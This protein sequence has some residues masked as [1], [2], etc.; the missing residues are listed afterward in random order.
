MSDS[1]QSLYP[2]KIRIWKNLLMTSAVQA[3][4][5]EAP[6]DFANAWN[7]APVIPTPFTVVV[8]GTNANNAGYASGTTAR[9]QITMMGAR[10]ESL[11][12][13]G[14]AAVAVGTPAKAIV[15]TL[16]A[17]PIDKVVAYK[18]YRQLGGAGTYQLIGWAD[19]VRFPE[20]G[21]VDDGWVAQS[22]T[23]PPG[24]STQEGDTFMSA[25]L[26]PSIQGGNAAQS[27]GVVETIQTSGVNGTKIN[28][29]EDGTLMLYPCETLTFWLQAAPT[30]GGTAEIGVEWDEE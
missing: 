25:G 29:Y 4:P 24:A 9:Y 6:Y 22:T 13:T 28:I 30:G 3:V 16:T 18:I 21:F 2:E 7:T 23:V 14:P 5:I 10:G 8:S 15:I 11:P 17:P 20:V 19:P 27:G 26:L 12:Y 1:T